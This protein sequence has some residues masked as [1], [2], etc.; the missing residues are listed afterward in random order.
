[1]PESRTSEARP[2]A[3]DVAGLSVRAG[4]R[5]L[6]DDLTFRIGAGERVGLIGESGS[7]KSLTSLAVMG[8]LPDTVTA[9]GRVRVGGAD[10]DIVGLGEREAARLR[11]SA[12]AMVFQEPMTALNPL[13]RVGRQIAEAMEIHRTQPDRRAARRRAVEMLADVGLPS[14]EEAARAYPHQLSGGQRQRV[15]LAIALANDPA[16]LVADEPT[17]ALDVT[18][19]KQVLDLVL[20]TVSQRDTGLLFI[21]HDLAVVGETC[22][23]VLVMNAGVVVEEGPIDRVFTRPE[24]P[25]TRGLL[26]ASDLDATDAAGRLFTVATAEGYTPGRSVARMDAGRA[27]REAAPAA[28]AVVR[29]SGLTKTYTR[30]RSSLFAAP[31]KVEALRGLDFEIRAGDRF[32]IVGESG[33]GKSTLLRILSGLDTPT[34]GAIEVVGRDLTT[35]RR[36]DLAELRSSLQIVFQDPMA[37]LDPRMRVGDIVAEPLLNAANTGA[38]VPKAEREARV[39]EMIRAVGLPA[40]SVDRYPHQFSGGQRQRISIARALVCRPRILVADEPVSALDVSVRAQ[41]L[42]LLADLVEEY[43]LTLIFVSHDLG[44][45]RYLCDRVA[46]MRSG[47]IVEQG[48]TREI[49]ENPADDYTR[50]LIA[51]TP[52]IRHRQE[53]R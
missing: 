51:A 12:V 9:T 50:A 26:A 6:V 31:Q 3:L 17:T 49:Y 32:G 52:S 5:L 21:T 33:S 27:E 1:M 15:V 45:V 22:D 2:S 35:H 7:G 8:L 19:Q 16:L 37:S 14:P 30:G 41:V 48:S 28:P 47:E 13:M 42:N 34:A 20:R 40:D 39:A 11:G 10:T 29:A 43:R 46:V 18:V 24:H 4:E 25:Y 53:I 36:A 44:V 23:R 38:A